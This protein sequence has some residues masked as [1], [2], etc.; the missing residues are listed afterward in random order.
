M[1]WLLNTAYLNLCELKYTELE[2]KK[3]KAN[4][5]THIQPYD[6]NIISQEFYPINFNWLN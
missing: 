6:L 1:L 3:T 2:R 5:S 4:A